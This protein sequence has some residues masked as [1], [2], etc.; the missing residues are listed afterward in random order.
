MCKEIEIL[1]RA[2]G[3][4]CEWEGGQQE[5]NISGGD[6][7]D[8]LAMYAPTVKI[9][10]ALAQPA[11]SGGVH[12]DD[13]AVDAFAEAMKSKLA[14]ARAKGYSGWEFKEECSAEE[15]SESLRRHVEKGDPR[16][17]ANFCM[18]LYQRGEGIAAAPAAPQ[19]HWVQ[20][21]EDEVLVALKRPS[22]GYEDVAP[23]LVAE[24]AIDKD[25]PEYRT[26]ILPSSGDGR[27]V[28]DD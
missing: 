22:E 8:E 6:S 26:I 23:E 9:V 7:H 20:L 15:L 14:I 27:G 5:R 1:C 17:V 25:W 16:D 11:G 4:R 13:V 28:A 3:V 24:D 2:L 10:E 21:A 19:G 18:F 12:S